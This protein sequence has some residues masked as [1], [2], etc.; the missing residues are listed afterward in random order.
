MIVTG[1]LGAWMKDEDEK[2]ITWDLERFQRI[3]GDKIMSNVFVS[4]DGM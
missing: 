3:L 2:A 4:D 1:A